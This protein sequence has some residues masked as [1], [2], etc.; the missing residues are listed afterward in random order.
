MNFGSAL[1]QSD[2]SVIEVCVARGLTAVLLKV[3][4]MII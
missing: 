3:I 2:L 4:V 1:G